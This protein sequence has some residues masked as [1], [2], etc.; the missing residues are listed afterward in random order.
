MDKRAN[1][2]KRHLANLV[3]ENIRILRELDRV[4]KM[5]PTVE[6]GRALAKVANDLEMALDRAGHFGLGFSLEGLR[7]MKQGG[8]GAKARTG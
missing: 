3:Q 5:P 6:R 2:Y 7:V 8:G 4:G 1:E